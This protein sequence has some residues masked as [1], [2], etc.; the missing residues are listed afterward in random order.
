MKE[1]EEQEWTEI[2]TPQKGWFDLRL[3]EL[4][5]YRDLI[6][7]FVR[8]DFVTVYKQTILGPLWYLIQPLMTSLVYLV[9]FKNIANL[10]TDGQ[11]AMLF[12]LCGVSIWEYFARSLNTT[13]NT[14]IDNANI[15]GKVYFP[16]LTV[17]VSVVISNLISFGI[18]FLLFLGFYAFFWFSGADLQPNL[19]LLATP[20]LLLLMALFGL[21]LGIIVSS[22][23]TKYRDLRF[24]VQFG[25]QLFMYASPIIYP[26][27]SLPEKYQKLMIFNPVAPIIEGFRYA[28][29]GT[30]TISISMLAYSSLVVFVVFIFGVALFN[31]VEK[32]FMDT[33]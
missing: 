7:L 30:G 33:V 24:L 22:L 32:T 3:K 18:Q 17:P 15:F 29:L 11:P 2:I 10:S 9:V 21:G 28:F 5:Q 23:T 6:L 20:Y 27:S 4:W 12:Y 14:F 8:R 19:W 13:S 1:I 16:R 25:I 31:R 26:L